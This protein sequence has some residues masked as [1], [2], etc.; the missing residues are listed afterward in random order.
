MPSFRDITVVAVHGN[1]GIAKAIPALERTAAALPGCRKLLISDV[2]IE[3]AA[4]EQKRVHQRLGYRAYSHFVVYC[5]DRYI[6][7]D[8]ALIVQDD[9]W[10]LNAANWRDEWFQYDYIGGAT[11]A[12]LIGNSF[13]RWFTWIGRAGGGGGEPLVVQNGGFSL[14]SKRFLAA[15]TTH[16]I[17]MRHQSDPEL[18]NEDI[19]LCCFMR[20]ALER[21]GLR[22]APLAESK[23]F[24]FEHLFPGLHGDIDI[25]KIFGNHSRFRRLI[26]HD[27]VGIALTDEQIRQITWEDRVLDLLRHYGYALRHT[28][29]PQPQSASPPPPP[30]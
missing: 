7:T 28:P 12:A 21:I 18:N 22:F 3:Y 15:P 1:G 29:P 11:H 10:A 19:Q 30:R 24:S 5:L 27:E 4:A 8:Y 23:L 16:G 14:R 25:H 9:G 13:F 17:T 6:E 2:P 26:A 20:P